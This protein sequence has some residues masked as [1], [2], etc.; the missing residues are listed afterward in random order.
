MVVMASNAG[1]RRTA[2]ALAV[3]SMLVITSA[4]CSAT[5]N[6]A[7]YDF[8]G[9]ALN[10]PNGYGSYYT[11]Q[12]ALV[13]HYNYYF[14]FCGVMNAD[15]DCAA[16][17]GMLCQYDHGNYTFTA[18][19]AKWEAATP[20]TWSLDLNS[21]TVT[22]TFNNGGTCYPGNLPRTA[23]FIFSCGSSALS[24]QSCSQPGAYC[25][26]YLLALSSSYACG[27]GAPP[28][29][30]DSSSKLSGGWVFFIIVCVVTPVYI[31]GGCAWNHFRDKDRQLSW[32]DKCPQ[33]TFWFMVPGLV[34]DGCKF[35]MAKTKEMVGRA[36]GDYTSV[37]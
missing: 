34:K 37:A 26:P 31:I 36:R 17:G 19:V 3:A 18:I 13:T 2:L 30:D 35:T 25:K 16:S 21:K 5:L 12:D 9:L 22:A 29:S 8:S 33:H 11:C 24:V 14:N 6:G 10:N 4:S 32:K 15:Q 23:N 20:P 27:G 7:V 28:G 1:T